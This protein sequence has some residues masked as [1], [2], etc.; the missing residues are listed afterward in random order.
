MA[1]HEPDEDGTQLRAVQAHLEANPHIEWLWYDAWCLP[2]GDLTP[3]EKAEFVRML[4]EI[5]LLYLGSTVLILL[6]LSYLSRFWTQVRYV[7]RT[8]DLLTVLLHPLMS[9]I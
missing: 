6:D 7:R 3:E 2:Q 5:N 9:R 1:Q 4:R 8:R